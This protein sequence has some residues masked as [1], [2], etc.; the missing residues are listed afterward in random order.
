MQPSALTHFLE[1]AWDWDLSKILGCFGLLAAYSWATRLSFKRHALVFFCGVFFLFL[2]LS[3]PLDALS[4]DYL[5]SAHML[6]HLVLLLVVP[7]LLLLGLPASTVESALRFSFIRKVEVMFNRP[8]LAWW[9]ANLILWVWHIPVLYD[10][11]VANEGVHIVE[12]LSFLIS[13]T[14]FW[15]PLLTPV[16][17]LC[18]PLADGLIFLFLAAL[19]NM[20]LGILLTFADTV[21]YRSYVETDDPW[22]ILSF[23]R[24]DLHLSVL[25]DQVLGGVLMWVF[26]GLVFLAI[27]LVHLVKYFDLQETS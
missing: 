6:Q 24:N 21:L 20:A 19:S 8:W 5:F 13:S 18:L 12:H 7:P 22:K 15:W 16:K 23:I 14:I 2:S 3:S 27:T 10:K 1:H 11:A 26:G 9:L 4:D 25:Q 17:S